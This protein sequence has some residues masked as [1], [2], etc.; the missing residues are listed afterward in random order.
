MVL[1]ISNRLFGHNLYGVIYDLP[2]IN[3]SLQAGVQAHAYPGFSPDVTQQG[4]LH[5]L[6][7]KDVYK[8]VVTALGG[9]IMSLWEIQLSWVYPTFF[10]PKVFRMRQVLFSPLL[11]T[12]FSCKPGTIPGKYWSYPG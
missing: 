3:P 8:P 5:T 7:R 2:F 6:A 4:I 11:P 10:P 12:P 1:D 9:R